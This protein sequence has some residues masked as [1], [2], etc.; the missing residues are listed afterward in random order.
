MR[1]FLAAIGTIALASSAIAADLPIRAPAPLPVPVLTWTGFYIGG[2]VGGSWGHSDVS[3][4]SVTTN[5]LLT[6]GNVG[7]NVGT[8]PGP[9]RSFDFD[10]AFTGGFQAGY[11]Y[12]FFN[13]VVLGVEGDFEWTDNK[14]NDSF[15]AS[16]Q[17]PTDSTASKAEWF[18]TIR[19][20]LGYSFG[21]FLPYV[22]GGAAFV[23]TS[24]TLTIEPWTALA[25][26]APSSG[27]PRFAAST[28]TTSSGYAVGVGLEYAIAP[29]WS[30]KG[31]YLHLGFGSKG[32]D[33][34]FGTAGTTHSDVKLK[35]D[36]ARFGVNYRF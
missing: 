30:I 2:N 29:H 14:G 7:L 33:F 20:R 5:G 3:N 4:N 26:A 17:G 23:H 11:N 31:E 1:A 18:A 25:G 15:N 21:R 10:G 8:F 12:E 34:N 36:L 27:D 35:F 16:V 28:S 19:G 22:T 32:Y 9:N 6:S 24:A 13:H